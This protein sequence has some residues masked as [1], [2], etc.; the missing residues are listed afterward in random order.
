[1]EPIWEWGNNLIVSIQ[2][3]HN[4]V[5]DGFFNIVTFLGEVEFFLLIFPF[6]IWS[7]DKS[8]G[9]RLA[10]LALISIAFNTWAKLII[11]HPR[12]FEWPSEATTPVLKLNEKARGPGIPSGHTQSSLA[13]WFYLAY[14]FKQRWLWIVAT[15]LFIL[16]SFS[17]VYLGV[18]FPTDLLGGAILGLIILLLFVKFEQ[19]LASQLSAQSIWRQIGLAVMIPSLIILIHPHPDTLA[20]FSVLAGLGL[21]AIFDKQKIGFEVTGP[22]THRV[23]RFIVGV[24]VLVMIFFGLEFITPTSENIFHIPLD[25]FRHLVA[26]FW[27]SGGALWTFKRVNLA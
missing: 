21:G 8:I 4:P 23:I 1:M 24:I 13:M 3:V 6:V 20:T 19:I 16:I 15:I 9:L 26:G 17:R 10:Y 25:I 5:L 18:H 12:P 27:V 11:G 7:I 14:H 22:V 2:T